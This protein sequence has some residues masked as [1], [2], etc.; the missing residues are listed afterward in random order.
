MNK[1]WLEIDRKTMEKALKVLEMDRNRLEIKKWTLNGL[2]RNE[3]GQSDLKMDWNKLKIAE[4]NRIGSEF[5][6]N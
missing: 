5:T 4:W 3:N 1:N 2:E 6:R